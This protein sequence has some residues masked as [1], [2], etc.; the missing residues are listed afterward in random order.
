[1]KNI[2]V[3]ITL[4]FFQF[5]NNIIDLINSFFGVFKSKRALMTMIITIAWFVFGYMG[6]KGGH[7]MADFSAY[8]VAL[9]PFVIGY[10]YGETKRPSGSCNKDKCEKC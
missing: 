10:I 8:F 4:G 6:I 1:M 5:I 7:N 3:K 2:L 9:S